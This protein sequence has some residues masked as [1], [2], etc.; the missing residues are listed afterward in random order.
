MFVDEM[1]E[2]DGKETS[3][4]IKL[5]INPKLMILLTFMT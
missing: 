2:M 3:N 1:V 5:K 4:Q